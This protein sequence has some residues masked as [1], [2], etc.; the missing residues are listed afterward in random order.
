MRTV[1]AGLVMLSCGAMGLVVAASFRQR[2]H[3]LRQLVA[4]FQALESEISYAR[5]TL[6]EV[7]SRQKGQYTGVVGQFLAVL[8]RAMLDGTGESFA[9]IWTSGLNVL[10]V[11]GLPSWLLGE[12]RQVGKSL[13]QSDAAEQLKHLSVLQKRLEE[14][15]VEAR[16]EEEKQTRLW[17]YLGVFSGLILVLLLF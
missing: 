7:I 4:F 1:G 15:M 13:G 17:S 3:N 10:A 11:N 16:Q 5:S 12:L 6:P 14:A 2:V 8:E 9:E